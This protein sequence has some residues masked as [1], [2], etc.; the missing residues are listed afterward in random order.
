M[1]KRLQ[2]MLDEAGVLLGQVP[3]DAEAESLGFFAR[4]GLTL[5]DTMSVDTLSERNTRQLCNKQL[6]RDHEALL[7]NCRTMIEHA[8]QWRQSKDY[9]QSLREKTAEIC[10]ML[11][12]K[13]DAWVAGQ[14]P[15]WVV[16]T[17]DAVAGP[18]HMEM[19]KHSFL[20]KQNRL[21]AAMQKTKP[22]TWQ[23]TI[24]STS[25]GCLRPIEF[26]I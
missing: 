19:H 23:T 1:T 14:L 5:D 26:T 22:S 21:S 6:E 18:T 4:H 24:W 20:I 9:R 11:D 25:K 8:Q 17:P 7:G 10:E 13:M 12:R 16:E 3:K 15:T 2:L